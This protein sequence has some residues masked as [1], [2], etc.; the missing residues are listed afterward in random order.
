MLD[1][2]SSLAAL[3]SLSVDISLLI[4]LVT[5]SASHPKELRG[6]STCNV[7]DRRAG[8][9]RHGA[10]GRW[11][12]ELLFASSDGYFSWEGVALVTFLFG[13]AA[14]WCI[15]ATIWLLS[16]EHTRSE[17]PTGPSQQG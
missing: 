12:A 2:A 14:T 15:G 3:L 6:P 13:I 16:H 4:F 8:W 9:R 1:A 11:I 5:V 17:Q 10:E 7:T